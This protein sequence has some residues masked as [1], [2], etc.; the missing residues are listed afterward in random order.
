LYDESGVLEADKRKLLLDRVAALVDENLFGRAE[1]CQQ[2][3]DLLAKSLTE[4]GLFARPVMGEA[5]YLDTDG[6]EL[7]RWQHAWVRIGDEVVDGNVD[8]LCENPMVPA[9]I[10]VR[11]YWGPIRNTPA[12]RR[13]HASSRQFPSDGDVEKIWWPELCDWLHTHLV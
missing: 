4:L 2:F 9:L 6:R 3:A 5:S 10:S 7:F 1:M 11:P 12:D 8:S 13:L